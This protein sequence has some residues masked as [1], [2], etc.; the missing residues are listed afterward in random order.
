MINVSFNFEVALGYFKFK[1]FS[2]D[3][4]LYF[5]TDFCNIASCIFYG[6]SIMIRFCRIAQWL[7]SKSS[8][9]FF[10]FSLYKRLKN[11]SVVSIFSSCVL[12]FA[13]PTR[14]WLVLVV[15]NNVTERWQCIS[16]CNFSGKCCIHSPALPQLSGMGR[17]RPDCLISY[18]NN[19]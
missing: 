18:A 5:Q 7:L 8:S 17:R 12:W 16:A 13:D 6:M 11:T 15:G 3:I 4:I 19:N 14:S 2:P 9:Q 1:L 10:L